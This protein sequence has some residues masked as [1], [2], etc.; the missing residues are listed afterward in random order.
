MELVYGKLIVYNLVFMFLAF[1]GMMSCMEAYE[2][3]RERW[4]GLWVLVVVGSVAYPIGIIVS[5]CRLL[6]K[7]YD[8]V[9]DDLGLTD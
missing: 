9:N 3:K 8:F 5:L 4:Q 2:P 7:F 6:V 1:F